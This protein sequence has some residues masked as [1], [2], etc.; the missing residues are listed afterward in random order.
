MTEPFFYERLSAQD[1]SFL[2]FEGPTTHMHIGGTTLFD[3][4]PLAT[5]NGGVDIDRIRAYVASRLHA[6]PRYRQRLHTLPFDQAPAWV[7]ADLNLDYHVRHTSLPK[8]GTDEQLKSLSA[9]ILS[10]QLDRSKPL[11][12][13]WIVEGLRQKRFAMILKTHH[14]IV[15]GVS[16]VDLVAAL[17]R[18][19]TDASIPSTPAWRPRRPPSTVEVLRK[20]ATRFADTSLRFGAVVRNAWNAPQAVRERVA[21]GLDAMWQTLDAGLR[22]P[23]E[24]PLNRDIGPY[25]RFDWTSFDLGEV[26]T[27]KNRLGGTINDVVLATVAGAVRRFLHERRARTDGLDYRCIVPVNIRPPDAHGASGN[28]VSAWMLSLPIDEPDA[29]ARMADVCATTEGLRRSKQAHGI[30]VFTQLAEFAAP[31]LTLGVRLAARIEPYNLIV[32]NVPGPQ[33]TLYLLGAPML[34]GYPQVPL[35]EKQGLAVALLSYA[36]RL[37]WGFQADWDLVPDLHRFT[38][39]VEAS[40][41]ELLHA[42]DAGAADVP[43]V[44]A[45]EA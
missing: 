13:L 34:A 31:I 4:G 3:S 21:D 11:W 19:S 8:P 7:D 27:I 33:Q 23:A 2:I 29:R 15:D 22:S 24:T 14:C 26:K 32:T 1:S 10:Q 43:Q 28:R 12:E 20:E 40:F 44:P 42:A 38:A 35:F 41:R 36:G 17:L 39:A 5:R 9:R 16:G 6:I 25:R 30:E 18:P 45:K 37:H